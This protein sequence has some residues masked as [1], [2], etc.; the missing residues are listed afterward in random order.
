[1]RANSIRKYLKPVSIYGSR[2]TTINHAFATALAPTSSYDERIIDEAMRALG[3]TAH[4]ALTCVYCGSQATSWDHLVGLV[5]QK[6]LSGY[7][8]QI[9]NLVPCCA[10]CN[11]RKGGKD[12]RDYLRETTT[13]DQV[14]ASRTAMLERY[15]SRFAH[16]I[17]L[18]DARQKAPT[19]FDEYERI[20]VQIFELMKEADVLAAQLRAHI[21]PPAA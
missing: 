16:E 1:M 13:D 4:D 17:A 6:Q 5:K 12:W 18:E 21:R 8:H 11:S 3:Q 10:Q 14:L 7:G 15:L 19:E 2:S 9:G 20:R